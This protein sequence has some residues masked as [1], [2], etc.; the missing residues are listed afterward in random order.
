MPNPIDHPSSCARRRERS[1]KPG[2][3]IQACLRGPEGPTGRRVAH[4]VVMTSEH[5]SGSPSCASPAT[6]APELGAEHV[7]TRIHAKLDDYNRYNFSARQ[8]CG[9][10]VF[11]DLAQEFDALADLYAL[12]VLVPRVLFDMQAELYVLDASGALKRR[13]PDMPPFAANPPQRDHLAEG[14]HMQDGQYRIPVR[15]RHADHES[16]PFIPVGDVLGMI[17]LHPVVPLTAHDR[18][19]YEKYA[20][21]VGFQLHNRLL[22]IKIREH[23]R[24]IR[25]LVHDIGHNVIVP[26]MYFKLLF[27]QLEGKIQAMGE[28]R[29]T[30]SAG[31]RMPSGPEAEAIRQLGHLH[32]HL[33]EQYREIYRHFLQSSLFLETLLR[34]SHFDQ[35]HYVLQRTEIDIVQRVV[36]PQLERFRA[37]LEEK[38]I[39]VRMD[40]RPECAPVYV[41]VDVGLISQVLANLLSNAV[42]YTRPTPGTDHQALHCRVRRVT[43]AFGSG[44]HGAR[45]EVFTTGSTVPA[46]DAARLFDADFRGSNTFGEYG[47]G[48]GLHF[49]RG[50]VDLHGGRVGYEEQ[51]GGNAF[52][53]LLPCDAMA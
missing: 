46:E 18:F 39:E 17:I 26:N 41:P 33:D 36:A 12:A 30:L 50:I 22:H 48:H 45:V 29:E 4:K 5:H 8:I 53:F 6:S 38:G 32:E 49:V 19:Y 1:Q 47:T 25:S 31:G 40:M 24:F 16:L 27:R 43:D 23:I 11:F 42:K 9:F 10:N 13:N 14:P 52:Y 20:N 15:G 21:R 44:R 35:G 28:L 51:E 7:L 3:P 34:Q 37:R 2:R